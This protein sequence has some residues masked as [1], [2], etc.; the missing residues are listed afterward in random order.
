[1]L[2][3]SFRASAPRARDPES[4][5]PAGVLIE[6]IVVMDSG[7]A[8][9]LSS[10][11]ALRGP[12]GTPRNDGPCQL[13]FGLIATAVIGTSTMPRASAPLAHCVMRSIEAGSAEATPTA[14]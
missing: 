8:R 10:G 6:R 4:I 9:S 2:P 3:L 7:F 1:M 12:V 5:T 14:L 13:D 11:R